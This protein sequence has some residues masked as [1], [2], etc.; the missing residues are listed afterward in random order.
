[1]SLHRLLEKAFPT[2][3]F[4]SRSLFHFFQLCSRDLR[5]DGSHTQPRVGN[6]INEGYIQKD[7]SREEREGGCRE[8]AHTIAGW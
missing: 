8:L 5:D 1:M 4:T 6:L 2:L 7:R 3:T